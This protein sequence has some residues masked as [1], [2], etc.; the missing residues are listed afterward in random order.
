MSIN[1]DTRAVDLEK[2]GA[3]DPFWG[4]KGFLFTFGF[5][6]AEFGPH[7]GSWNYTHVSRTGNALTKNDKIRT[8]IAQYPCSHISHVWDPG[9][10]D[11][12]RFGNLMCG[13]PN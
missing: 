6:S 10:E 2:A 7:I 11:D 3:F 8:P 12:F 1:A 9:H 5:T 13:M 4:S